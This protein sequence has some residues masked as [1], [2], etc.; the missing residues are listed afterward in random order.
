M[1]LSSFKEGSSEAE[2]R[3]GNSPELLL[4]SLVD[5]LIVESA[6]RKSKFIGM[7]LL[8]DV[9]LAAEEDDCFCG[10]GFD[11]VVGAEVT[12]LRI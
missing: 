11:V 1:F 9:R 4:R 7:S 10:V 8:E 12:R 6:F 5:L 2:E 3:D